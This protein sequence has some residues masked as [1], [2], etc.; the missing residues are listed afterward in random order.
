MSSLQTQSLNAILNKAM[1]KNTNM[2]YDKAMNKRKKELER[3]SIF[4]HENQDEITFS[5][6]MRITEYADKN[7]DNDED[8]FDESC[9]RLFDITINKARTGRYDEIDTEDDDED[10]EDIYSSAVES[11]SGRPSLW[12]SVCHTDDEY[13]NGYERPKYR[14][15]EHTVARRTR[16]SV[17]ADGDGDGDGDRD[18]KKVNWVR[19]LLE[20]FIRVYFEGIL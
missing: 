17:Q 12:S 6:M 5:Y 16:D 7:K 13:Y 10:E 15:L 2:T 1:N 9:N 14:H 11:F 19:R 4:F 3:Q 8:L 18:R 20:P